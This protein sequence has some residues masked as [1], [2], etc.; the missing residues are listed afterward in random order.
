[1]DFTPE[2]FLSH[3]PAVVLPVGKEE[4]YC[5]AAEAWVV[6]QV[7]NRTVRQAALLEHAKALYVL[8][9]LHTNN[10]FQKAEK[11]GLTVTV[12]GEGS[13]RRESSGIKQH[14]DQSER[15]KAEAAALIEKA[16]RPPRGALR[17]VS[18]VAR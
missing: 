15:Y 7:N 2:Q 9:L 16:C 4:D 18:G 10:E 13:V 3:F 5:A 6:M 1:M 12:E 8:V 11:A 14:A 17:L